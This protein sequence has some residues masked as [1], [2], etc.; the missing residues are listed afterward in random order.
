MPAQRRLDVLAVMGAVAVSGAPLSTTTISY[1]H[2]QAS[3]M[4]DSGKRGLDANGKHTIQSR[5]R[6]R[7]VAH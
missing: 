4:L 5:G 1:I 7:H 6:L 2:K 3:A